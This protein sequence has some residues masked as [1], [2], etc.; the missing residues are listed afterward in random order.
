MCKSH[1][2]RSGTTV[3]ERKKE[4]E[5]GREKGSE[6]RAGRKK[7]GASVCSEVLAQQQRLIT[8]HPRRERASERASEA[9]GTVKF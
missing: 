5:A 2:V 4:R 7:K 1:V 8:N 3:E 6:S 9:P